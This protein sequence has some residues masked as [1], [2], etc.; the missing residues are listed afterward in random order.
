MEC[1]FWPIVIPEKLE[2]F[3]SVWNE[4]LVLSNTI[5]EEKTPGKLKTEFSTGN[6]E[7]IC[8]AP[9]SYYALCRD[10]NISKD[11]RKGIPNWTDL[12]LRD[13]KDILYNKENDKRMAEVRSLRINR[14]KKMTRTA[15]KKI[16]LT[17]IHVKLWVGEDR[18]TCSP[19]QFEGEYV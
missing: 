19:I 13:F 9:K 16:G 10:T 7:M 15:T 11:G 6:G 14:D 3:K 5:E 18:V 12:R 17:S 2:E 8:L 4:W 1:V